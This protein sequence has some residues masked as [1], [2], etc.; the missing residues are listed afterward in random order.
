MAIVH[1]V[2]RAVSLQGQKTISLLLA[3]IH[4]CW[5]GGPMENAT[6]E[7]SYAMRKCNHIAIMHMRQQIFFAARQTF[8]KQLVSPFTFYL[9]PGVC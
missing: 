1:A 5:S 6:V 4:L 7:E 9:G 8:A 3:T 2:I